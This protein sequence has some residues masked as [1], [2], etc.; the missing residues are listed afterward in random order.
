[1]PDFLTFCGIASGDPVLAREAIRKD[2]WLRPLLKMSD[3]ELRELLDAKLSRQRRPGTPACCW[4][5]D[6]IA[7]RERMTAHQRLE[8]AIAC[9]R[10]ARAA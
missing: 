8:D 10:V 7:R 6:E 4:I 3:D 9:G 2:R 5:G 1:M